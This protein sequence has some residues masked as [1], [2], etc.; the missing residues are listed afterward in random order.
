MGI[1]KL[2]V[3]GQ[4][5]LACESASVLSEDCLTKAVPLSGSTVASDYRY[6]TGGGVHFKI[7]NGRHILIIIP[8]T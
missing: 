5:H 8:W 7:A 6:Y 1:F 4:M 2:T 3:S